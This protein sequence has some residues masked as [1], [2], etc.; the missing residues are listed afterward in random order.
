MLIVQFECT[1]HPLCFPSPTRSE[2]ICHG[3]QRERDHCLSVCWVWMLSRHLWALVNEPCPTHLILWL[4]L[5]C[6]AGPLFYYGWECV[7]RI[8]TISYPTTHTKCLTV[9]DSLAI[10]PH[11]FIPSWN[12][13]LPWCVLLVCSMRMCEKEWAHVGNM[14]H[15]TIYC[16]GTFREKMVMILQWYHYAF[17]ARFQTFS[18]EVSTL[19]CSTVA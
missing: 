16:R 1:F 6:L 3:A 19:L 11:W 4:Q 2:G 17:W 15:S 7:R 13:S 14:F 5:H 9:A 8:I 12:T 10:Q 18:V